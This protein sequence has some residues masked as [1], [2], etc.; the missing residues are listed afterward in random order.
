M[1]IR[2][3]SKIN[4][5]LK[6]AL[7]VPELFQNPTIEQ[8]A[9]AIDGRLPMSKR[10]SAVISMQEGRAEPSVYFIYA[11]PEEFRLAQLMGEGRSVFGIES[12]WP[13]AWRNAA[14]SNETSALPTME[15]M[16]A[17]YAAALSAHIRSSPCVLAGWSFAGMMAFEA[18]HQIQ[19]QGGKVDLVLLIDALA[20]F[21]TPYQGAWH[22]LRQD[23]KQVANG[24]STDRI[25]PLFKGAGK[26]IILRMLGK[27]IKWLWSLFKSEE[28]LGELT[29]VF[30]EEGMPLHEGLMFRSYREAIKNYRLRCLDCRGI[31]F[32]SAAYDEGPANTD[33]TLA[34][35]KLFTGGL[36]IVPVTGD[37]LSMV[38]QAPHNLTLAREMNAALNRFYQTNA[39]RPNIHAR[40]SWRVPLHPETGPAVSLDSVDRASG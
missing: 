34:W 24:L 36:E 9:R 13:L 32:R 37:H 27:E 4:R 38:R 26:I 16:V 28:P 2:L 20:K 10:S 39:T 15:Q 19:A 5:T 25:W 29:T 3:I 12:P 31:L 30:D 7:G 35:E 40:E 17:P 14:A 18:A 33:G 11:G 22:Q 21:R 6:V 1:V 23:W 8:M